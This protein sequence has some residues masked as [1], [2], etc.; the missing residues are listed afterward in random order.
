MQL[1]AALTT[2]RAMVR[3]RRGAYL[4]DVAASIPPGFRVTQ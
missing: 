4:T 2:D 3:L 1:R